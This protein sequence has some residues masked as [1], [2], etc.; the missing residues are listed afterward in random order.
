[1]V[2]TSASAMF[3]A[4]SQGMGAR[5]KSGRFDAVTVVLELLCPAC[6]LGAMRDRESRFFRFAMA[7]L[8]GLLCAAARLSTPRSFPFVLGLFVAVGVELG[9][10]RSWELTGRGLTIG[11]AALLPVWGWTFSQGMTPLSWFR[12]I[13]TASQGDKV[14]VSPMLHGSWHLL[15]EPLIPLLSGF[16]FI[17]L[18]ILI[19]GSATLTAQRSTKKRERDF[20]S[21][22]RL[23]SIAVLIN[24][25]ATF[26][27]IARSWDYEIFFVPL[28]MPV[29]IALTARVLR[30]ADSL[31]IPRVILGSWLMLAIVLAAIRSGKVVAW[32]ASYQE[33]DP[34]PLQSFIDNNIAKDSLLLCGRGG[35]LPL[36]VRASHFPERPGHSAI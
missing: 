22:P 29:L 19:F 35:G 8:A 32:A 4:L 3:V 9:L 14:S 27:A 6:T 7:V 26:L 18:M 30:C 17:F 34:K 16:L 28:A 11:A 31:V 12:F 13:L 2:A 36:S 33:R 10:A 1:M 20:V 24:Y 21:G 23:A 5:A 15:D 25:I